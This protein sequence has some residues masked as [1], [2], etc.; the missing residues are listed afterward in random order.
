M[1][2][3]PTDLN[4]VQLFWFCFATVVKPLIRPAAKDTPSLGWP[5]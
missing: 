2:E 4:D 5:S 3:Q 1:E